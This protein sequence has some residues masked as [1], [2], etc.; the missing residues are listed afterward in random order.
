[1]NFGAAKSLLSGFLLLKEQTS[2]EREGWSEGVILV[3]C[4][5]KGRQHLVMKPA[6]EETHELTVTDRVRTEFKICKIIKTIESF[7]TLSCTN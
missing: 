5:K 3:I 6:D 2:F 4:Q 7:T 1:M